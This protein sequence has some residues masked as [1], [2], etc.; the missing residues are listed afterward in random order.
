[1]VYKIFE[2][3]LERLEKKLKAIEAKCN[4]YGCEF[5]YQKIGEE[6]ETVYGID[7]EK[8]IGKFILV[9]A[10]GT[11][12]LNGW[13]FVATIQHE[14]PLNVIRCFNN[15]CD[16]PQKYYVAEPVCEHCGSN[17]HRKDTYLVCNTETGEFKQV[18]KSCLKVFTN[19]L[20]AEAVAR[21]IS[22]FDE[23]INGRAIDECQF[24]SCC[25][26]P[27][28]DVLR[29]AVEAVNV[30]GYVKTRD[31]Y[32]NAND[33]STCSVVAN[34][35]GHCGA[36]VK[37]HLDR[38]FNVDREGNKEKAVAIV[39]YVTS[40]EM[41]LG[42]VSNLKTLLGKEYCTWRDI[43]IICSAVACY[44]KEL[45]RQEQKRIREEENASLKN[46][47]FGVV[48]ERVKIACESCKLLTSWESQFGMVHIYKF[49]SNDGH[50]FTW[51]TS[52]CIAPDEARE[53]VGTVKAHTEYNGLK[54]TE[55]TR[56]KV[57]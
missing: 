2:G 39:E 31:E 53:V 12:K 16:I 37:K 33:N 28:A 9:E 41:Q 42:Y 30:Y 56:C 49:V 45:E 5:H 34:F 22:F 32:G 13:E 57:H 48:G 38:G 14:S 1:M 21:Y 26:Y 46:D 20:S 40:M 51:K 50:V 43:G 23:L 27:V 18:G 29:Y 52:S 8:A 55:L 36:A 44:N 4:K 19:G 24:G 25:Y 35:L 11:A 15:D 47:W 3:N 7:G 10:S 6:Y 17:R 54:Q